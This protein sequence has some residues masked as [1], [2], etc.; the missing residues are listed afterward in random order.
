MQ[1]SFITSQALQPE[2]CPAYI[3]AGGRSSRF[4]SDKARV[5]VGDGP[6]LLAL[7]RELRQHGHA[8]EFVADR[9]DRYADL[10]LEC[11][12]DWLPECGPLAGLATAL[13]HRQQRR[14]GWL[15]LLS[16]D[17][18][19][20]RGAWFE[21][22]RGALQRISPDAQQVATAHRLPTA[23]QELDGVAFIRQTPGDR[24]Q[25]EP[26][27]SLLHSR[28]GPQ[29]VALLTSQQRALQTLF[30]QSNT[31]A[32]DAQD[33]PQAWTFNTAEQLRALRG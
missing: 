14:P 25:V 17:L 31:L 13:Q 8:V 3:L 18:L 7:R 5:Q 23:Q 24:Q 30:E 9:A 11:L 32:L 27:P 26:F 28:L 15:L 20:W 16:C 4:G 10:G 21:Q 2:Q 6:L 19:V 1:P 22:L 33:K 12:V 29:A